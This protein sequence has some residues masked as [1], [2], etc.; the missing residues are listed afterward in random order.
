MKE[1]CK[2]FNQLRLVDAESGLMLLCKHLSKV[3]VVSE[4]LD[5]FVLR[6][7]G[8]TCLPAGPAEDSG[9]PGPGEEAAAT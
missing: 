6:S 5:Y 1:F 3:V 4:R 9:D 8:H 2:L 7:D